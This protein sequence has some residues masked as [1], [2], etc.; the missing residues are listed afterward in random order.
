MSEI[1]KYKYIQARSYRKFIG[2]RTI[3]SIILHSTDGHEQGDVVTLTQGEV[4]VHWY[5]T[6]DGRYY[7]FVQ[8]NDV[9]WHAGGVDIEDHS[10][11]YSI[12]IEQEHMDGEE[13]WPDIQIKAAARLV[14][15]LHQHHNLGQSIPTLSHASVARPRGRKE[16]PLNYPWPLFSEYVAEFYDETKDDPIQ[17]QEIK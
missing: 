14:A 15:F 17:L 2:N 16:D 10:N 8:D 9:A 11:T 6:K 7:H 12:G 13:N 1:I 5:V 4:S 3:K